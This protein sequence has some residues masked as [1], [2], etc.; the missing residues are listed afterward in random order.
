MLPATGTVD[1]QGKASGQVI[2]C[3][4]LDLSTCS[5]KQVDKSPLAE[6][7]DLSTCSAKQV[8]KSCPAVTSCQPSFVDLL[9]GRS[10]SPSTLCG[11]D[12]RQFFLL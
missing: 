10:T 7:L 1:L 6:G 9:E 11:G 12:S 5:V 8:D 3:L 4:P 2:C